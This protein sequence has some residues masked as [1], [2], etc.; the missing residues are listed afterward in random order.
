[1]PDEQALQ[2]AAICRDRATQ[3]SR[4]IRSKMF[5]QSAQGKQVQLLKQAEALILQSLDD[6]ELID[7]DMMFDCQCSEYYA[8]DSELTEGQTHITLSDIAELGHVRV[9]LEGEQSVRTI[10][11]VLSDVAIPE[12]HDLITDDQL[13]ISDFVLSNGEPMLIVV[14]GENSLTYF[15]PTGSIQAL[16]PRYINAPTQ[17]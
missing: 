11:G 3:T 10:S 7:D 12:I 17:D 8:V 13:K 6:L 4:L 9:A 1:M 5:R 16:A 14:D 15:I 2:V